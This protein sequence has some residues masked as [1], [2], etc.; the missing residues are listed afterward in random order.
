MAEQ[1]NAE[2]I[3][4]HVLAPIA[5]YVIGD[6]YTDPSLYARLEESA[7]LEAEAGLKTLVEKAQK[8][9]VKVKSMLL[10]GTTHE[11][12]LRAAKRCKADVV[13]IGTHGRSG[14][15]RLLMGSVAGRVVSA[16]SCPVLTVRGR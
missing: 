11:Q 13:V 3:L 12:I 7:R 5:S 16:A 14:I 4:L 9:K 8:A 2:L 1:N 10:R 6:H 15:S